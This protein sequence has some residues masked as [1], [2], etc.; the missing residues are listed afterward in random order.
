MSTLFRSGRSAP[1][2]FCT[3]IPLLVSSVH[4]QSAKP[5]PLTVRVDAS[6]RAPRLL[7]N[8]APRRARIFWGQPAS[9]P[10]RLSSQAR[11]IQFEFSPTQSEPATATMHF[12][13]GQIPGDV[14]L[15]TIRVTDLETG[16]EV[17]SVCEFERGDADFARDWRVWPPA[18][19]NT[20]GIFG[21]VKGKG[22]NGSSAL[23]VRLQSPPDGVWP[24]FH[25]YFRPE[26][27]LEKG[28]RYRVSFW[29]RAEPERDLTVAFYRPGSSFVYLGGP[30]GPF[31]S[32]IRLA[33]RAG[34]DLVSF[35]M[36]FPWHAPGEPEDWQG[37]DSVCDMVLRA[38]PRALMIPRIGLYVPEWWKQAHPDE[39]MRWEDGLHQG[40]ASPASL[41]YRRDASARLSALIR[42]LEA[43]YGD[44]IAGYHPTGQNTGEWFYMDSWER[45]L[46]GY[47]PCDAAAFRQW[48][49]QK[50]RTT[51]AL[52]NAW[53]DDRVDFVNAT[54][55]SPQ[56]RH[57]A[58]GGIFRIPA[59]E[60]SLID[61]TLF[62]QDSMAE[63]VSE[64]ARTVRRETKGRKLVVF[65]YG[66]VFEFGALPT[67]PGSSGHYALRHVLNSPD[68]DILCA[69][70]SYFDRGKG[71]SAPCMTAA[72][73]VALAGK[74]WLNEDDTRT[75][76]TR[77]ANFPGAEH[78]LNTLE[79]TNGLLRRNTA[80]AAMRNFGTWWMDLPGS[81]WFDDPGM[82]AEMAR[83]RKLDEPL[84]K[85]PL[86]FRPEIAVVIDELSMA[87]IAEGGHLVT[88]P[89]V[90]E[91]RAA[92]GR[93]GAPYGQYLLDDVARGRVKAKLYIFLNAWNLSAKTREQLLSA[94]RGALRIWCYAPGFL[95]GSRY[96]PE[97]MRQ[98]TGFSL[99]Q[100]SPESARATPTAFGRKEGLTP[101]G[102][103]QP[104][105]PLFAASDASDKETLAVYPDGSASITLKRTS[106]GQSLF[107]GAPG[108][109]PELLRFAA[110]RAGVR[111]YTETDCCVYVNGAFVALH[112]VK[113]GPVLLLT[114]S[115]AV[116]QDVLTGQAAGRGPRLTI[117]MRLGETRVLRI[118]DEAPASARS[119]EM[120]RNR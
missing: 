113:D 13:F 54:V 65:F 106:D 71:Q 12:R 94:T 59:S 105:Y 4:A 16:R 24:D 3:L 57:A 29:A 31:E 101:F 73:S 81:G 48:L 41:L 30:S 63:C 117:E 99:Q 90:Y 89:A 118:G 56:A 45:P 68:I 83:L 114:G 86:P 50:Y 23:H 36:P 87:D 102:V 93:M 22:Q 43:K 19:Q 69:P 35:E 44:R 109:T 98:L 40:I 92:L 5:R 6:G 60:Q 42:H 110:R 7:V 37:V 72:E 62:Q 52:R 17:F 120:R 104:I 88:R 103:S 79:E 97:A 116:V 11:I 9:R 34:V 96:A 55:P 51:E 108:L 75:H 64:L 58:P 38:N 67:G 1:L 85:N 53:R 26:L 15:D 2:L 66:Y 46:N 82:W 80:Q 32:Q 61:F 20:V 112:A 115:R 84:L 91:A 47:A 8:G 33:A 70:I 100:V 28:H 77:E 10:I 14:Y 18:P 111:L 21:V 49:R 95:E 78:I 74:M 107:V 119:G 39:L 76:L 25:I 27:T